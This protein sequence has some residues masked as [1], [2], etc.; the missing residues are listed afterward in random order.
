M[1]KENCSTNALLAQ[2]LAQAE[3]SRSSERVL[4]LRRAPFALAR[5]REGK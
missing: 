1:N 2:L 5:A 4:S 3:G